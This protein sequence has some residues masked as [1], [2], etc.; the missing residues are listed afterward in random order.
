[1]SNR[2]SRKRERK[3]EEQENET[4]NGTKKFNIKKYTDE[5]KVK[6]KKK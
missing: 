4:Y 3:Y 5:I 2:E 1:M 6:K